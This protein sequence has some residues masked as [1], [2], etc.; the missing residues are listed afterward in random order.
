M[1]KEKNVECRFRS[2]TKNMLILFKYDELPF[3]RPSSTAATAGRRRGQSTGATYRSA[4]GTHAD[5][6]PPIRSAI[7]HDSAEND[8]LDRGKFRSAAAVPRFPA[9]AHAAPRRR[10]GS[11]MPL[12]PR[13]LDARV[14]ARDPW[15]RRDSRISRAEHHSVPPAMQP[16]RCHHT[17][18]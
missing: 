15:P 2:K 1:K 10:D 13:A 5:P 17:V 12:T 6:A 9:T 8:L 7:A 11:T 4:T 18:A 14:L 3:P 16:C